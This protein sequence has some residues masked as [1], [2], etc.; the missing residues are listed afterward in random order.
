MK[1]RLMKNNEINE[2][3]Y[4]RFFKFVD[5]LDNIKDKQLTKFLKWCFDNG[6]FENISD[7]DL[8]NNGITIGIDFYGKSETA[9]IGIDPS[10][11]FNK[12][13]TSSILI[14][15]PLSKR[16]EKQMYKYLDKLLD[17][18]NELSIDWRRYAK[19]YW[20]GEYRNF[21]CN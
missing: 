12:I 13:K 15:L 20:Y 1:N 11:C 5:N 4:N 7:D 10:K 19:E 9:L 6:F 2:E 16:E 21:N 14:N 17:K 8:K 3:E 18:K